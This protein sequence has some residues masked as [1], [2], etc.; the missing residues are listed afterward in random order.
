MQPPKR[1]CNSMRGMF[2]HRC[3]SSPKLKLLRALGWSPRPFQ[4]AWAVG[5]LPRARPSWRIWGP[6][7]RRESP[8]MKH[9]RFYTKCQAGKAVSTIN[10]GGAFRQE[11]RRKGK[12]SLIVVLRFGTQRAGG[13]PSTKPETVPAYG[14]GLSLRLRA[15]QPSPR[16]LGGQGARF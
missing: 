1:A 12:K 10:R 3:S 14:H 9:S 6:L 4:P 8:V 11:A 13:S 2:S 7:A 5:S 16:G 15:L